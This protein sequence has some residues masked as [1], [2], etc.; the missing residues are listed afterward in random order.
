MSDWLTGDNPRS[1]V[2]SERIGGGSTSSEALSRRRFLNLVVKCEANGFCRRNQKV[3]NGETIPDQQKPAMYHIKRYWIDNANQPELLS[4]TR[5]H[6]R[7]SPENQWIK[8]PRRSYHVFSARSINANDSEENGFTESAVQSLSAA[9]GGFERRST[10]KFSLAWAEQIWTARQGN[11]W[12]L[13][14]DFEIFTTSFGWPKVHCWLTEGNWGWNVTLQPID[15]K[16][17]SLIYSRRWC[18][19]SDG[20]R[21]VLVCFWKILKL[22]TCFLF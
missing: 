5:C 18:I 13:S 19:V 11:F 7:S 8:P 9:E 22:V 6:L 10:R 21:T 4:A 12:K 17:K 14:A 15:F 20:P 2:T 3:W 1:R 16:T